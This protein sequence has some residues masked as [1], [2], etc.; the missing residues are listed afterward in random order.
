MPLVAVSYS[1]RDFGPTVTLT[2]LVSL[3]ILPVCLVSSKEGQELQR[4]QTER[5]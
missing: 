4:K 2:L 3:V 5:E 1:T